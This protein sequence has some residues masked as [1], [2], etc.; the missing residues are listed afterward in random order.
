MTETKGFR[1]VPEQD[2][3]NSFDVT[4]HEKVT[5]GTKDI[6]SNVPRAKI[7]SVL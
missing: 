4:Q 7:R 6:Q 5:P 3:K 2:S 1:V